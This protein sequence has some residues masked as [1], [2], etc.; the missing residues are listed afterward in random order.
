VGEPH[1]V[2]ID[3]NANEPKIP[4]RLGMSTAPLTQPIEQSRNIADLGRQRDVFFGAA[5]ARP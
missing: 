4:Q 2:L 3:G 5:H 1:V